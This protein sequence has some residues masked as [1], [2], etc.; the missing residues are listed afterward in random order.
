MEKN[1]AM[2]EVL[3]DL[4]KINNDR[5]SE[6]E[7]AISESKELDIDLKGIFEE[8][9]HQSNQYK[10]ELCEKI[11]FEQGVVEDEGTP[12][13]KI[14]L[15]WMN[16]KSSFSNTDRLSI[17]SACEFVE[18]AAQRA[19]ESAIASD[20]LL[21]DNVRALIEQQRAGLRKSHDMIKKQHEVYK[22]LQK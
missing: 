6:Y 17:L 9:V 15:A 19:Y 2:N 1:E 11:R 12:S 10:G 13:G 14:Y 3:N 8:M 18:D 20:C 22:A 5:I 21:D 16:I 7:R 4:V